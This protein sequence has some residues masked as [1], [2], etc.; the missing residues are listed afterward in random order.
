MAS[1]FVIRKGFI[2]KESSQ[3]TG[4][5]T[6]TT[7]VSASELSGSFHGDGTN[8][9]G[10]VSAS[11]AITASHLT[12]DVV[13]SSYATTSS[14]STFAESSTSASYATTASYA[15][16]TQRPGFP[17]NG[18]AVITGSLTVSGSVVSGSFKGDGSQLT[19]IVATIVSSSTES[20]TFSSV[21]SKTVTHNLG[22]KEVFVQVYNDN[23]SV[24]IPETITTPT[25]NTVTVT[26][27]EN[28]SG[29]VVVAKGGHIVSGSS[30][31]QWVDIRN[32]PTGIVSSSAQTVANLNNQ[33]V[34]LGSGDLI[35]TD[36]T[37]NNNIG[38]AGDL[39]HIGDS[40]NAIR[41]STD[42]QDFLTSN[43]SRLVIKS[44]GK[45]GIN[46]PTPDELLDVNGNVKV[47]GHINTVGDITGSTALFQNIIVNATAS[48]ARLESVTSGVINVGDSKIKLNTNTPTVR[49]GG[50]DVFDS[51]SSYDSASLVWDGQSHDW[52][53]DYNLAGED[54]ESAV[55]LTGPY[56]T[57]ANTVYPTNNEIQ[58]GTNSHHL[59][60]SNVYSVNGNVGINIT[61]PTHQLDVSGDSALRGNTIL[62]A[63]NDGGLILSSSN[64]TDENGIIFRR[65]GGT[66]DEGIIKYDHTNDS[67]EFVV[68]GSERMRISS[69]GNMG[70]GTS[71]PSS[72]L[73]VAGTITATNIEATASLASA[74][75]N[76]NTSNTNSIKFWNG[77]QAQYDALGTYDDNTIY[78]VV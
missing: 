76:H 15:L 55:F 21:T 28:R 59:T 23:D 25:I 61:S 27:T 46:Q 67:L 30:S 68:S 7:F 11:Y 53:Y 2:S 48:I 39:F 3:I 31:P 66:T 20:D 26:F 57:L 56:S 50:I 5:L 40:D 51:G 13:S 6:A 9:T 78:F 14:Y 47:A 10:V 52:K 33:D 73:E 45:I 41:F 71:N 24:I 34:D 43:S 65:D 75:I 42:Q 22:T 37:F 36:G 72:D 17:F 77:T 18:S 58:K 16:N 19:G 35:A 54:H 69:N 32:L 1:E 29:K 38:V 63:G 8:I 74:S 62:F 12:G 4:S 70:I 49:Y 44:D 64:A 60:G